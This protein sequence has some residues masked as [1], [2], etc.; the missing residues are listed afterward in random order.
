LMKKKRS[1]VKKSFNQEVDHKVP[2]KKNARHKKLSIKWGKGGRS[3][4]TRAQLAE[5]SKEG[6]TGKNRHALRE[7]LWTK[8]TCPKETKSPTLGLKLGDQC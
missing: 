5:V 1:R 3:L 8:V 2:M 6:R 4:K 7:L